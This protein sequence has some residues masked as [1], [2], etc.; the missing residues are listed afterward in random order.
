M[1]KEAEDLRKALSNV[2]TDESATG[3]MD[4]MVA[5]FKSLMG[6]FATQRRKSW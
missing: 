4:G 5:E 3:I 6:R 1:R 2:P